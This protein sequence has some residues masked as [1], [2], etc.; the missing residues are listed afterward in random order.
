MRNRKNNHGQ[1]HDA[2]PSQQPGGYIPIDDADISAAAG[3]AGGPIGDVDPEEIIAHTERLR[4][5]EDRLRAEIDEW[6]SKYQR[7]LA[8][9][10][11]YQRRSIENEREARRQGVISVVQGLLGVLD[12]F[13]L[14]LRT[15]PKAVSAEQIAQGVTLIKSQLMQALSA[16]GVGVI[17]PRPGDEFDPHRHEAVVQ[18]PAAEIEPGRV[19]ASFQAG[20]ILGDRVLRPAKVSIATP[21]DESGTGD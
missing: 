14:A 6:K 7:A 9:F 11:N 4:A 13:D 18:I 10:T 19:A 3:D 21:P 16:I 8:D 15:D 1:G 17:E 20:Y 5:L 12:N 2:D